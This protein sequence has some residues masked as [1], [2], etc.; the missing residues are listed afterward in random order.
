M[1]Q[2]LKGL[3]VFIFLIATQSTV[4]QNF[5]DPKTQPQFVNPLPIPAVI[6]A[7]SGGTF[8]VSISQFEQQLG[9]IDPET[10]QPLTTKV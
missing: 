7:R 3:P 4:A 9:L 6:D 2:L 1:R 8:T 10:K 5:L